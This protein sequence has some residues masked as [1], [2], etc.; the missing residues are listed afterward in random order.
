MLLFWDKTFCR[1][2]VHVY[3][4]IMCC[5]GSTIQWDVWLQ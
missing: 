2:C 1:V 4:I 3:D 5:V